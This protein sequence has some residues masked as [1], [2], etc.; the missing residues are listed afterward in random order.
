MV[1]VSRVTDP[2]RASTRPLTVLPVC[3]DAEVKA[4][5][6]PTKVVLVP[7]VAELP[8]WK[9]TLQGDTP[10]TRLTVLSDAV[11]RV[12]PAWKMNTELASPFPSK[13]TVPVRPSAPAVLY[14]PATKV[15]PPRLVP[16]GPVGDRPAASLYAVVRSACACA[17]TASAA[18]WV[19]LVTTPGGKPTIAV[20]GLTPPFP[21]M[22]DGP[23]LVTV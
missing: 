4:R 11:I 16:A 3:T 23:V 14:T 13:V 5:M 22:F 19:P 9:N 2:L 20:P 10:L 12:D 21:E 17:A 6:L 1:L 15:F 7:R 8:T 18:C